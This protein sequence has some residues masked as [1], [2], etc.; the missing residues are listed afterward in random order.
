M[1]EIG[2]IITY[3]AAGAKET[4]LILNYLH[5]AIFGQK[6]LVLNLG[7]GITSQITLYPA[8]K[9]YVHLHS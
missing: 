7:T 2:D 8:D 4:F 1:Y 9:I 6:Y 3:S 5:E